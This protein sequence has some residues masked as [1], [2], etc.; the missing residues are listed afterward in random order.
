MTCARP[1]KLAPR[2]WGCVVDFRQSNHEGELIGWIQE[3]RTAASGIILNAGGHSLTPR[4]AYWTALSAAELP[5]IEVHLSN[6]FRRE[7]PASFL[8]V[9]GGQRRDLRPGRQWIRACRRGHGQAGQLG[10]GDAPW[11]GTRPIRATKKKGR[12]NDVERRNRETHQRAA[13][14]SASLRSFSTIRA[15][16]DRD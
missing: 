5:V 4:L 15:L 3:A 7:F 14:R 13:P 6:I 9:D 10:S 1:P 12:A 11:P 8:C 2:R 16:G